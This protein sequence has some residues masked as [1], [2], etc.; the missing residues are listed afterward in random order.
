MVTTAPLFDPGDPAVAE[1]PYPMYRRLREAEPVHRSPLGFWVLSRYA[2]V[3]LVHQDQRFDRGLR[4]GEIVV[5]GWGGP[6]TVITR[7]ARRWILFM[8]PPDHT[9]IRGLV[10]SAF[11]YRTMAALRSRIQGLVDELIDAAVARGSL[12]VMADVAHP[13]PVTVISDL[14]GLPVDDHEQCRRW[15]EA[16]GHVFEPIQTDLKRQRAAQAIEEVSEYVRS[17]VVRR[18][19]SPG[20][21]LLTSLIA[22]EEAGDRLSDEELVSTVNLLLM[23]GHETTRNLIG[24]G[25]MALLRHPSEIERLRADPGLSPNAVEE[26]LRYDSPVQINRRMTRVDVEL[27]GQRIAAGDR[28]LTVIGAAH[29]DPSVFADPDVLDVSRPDVRP[30]SF[31]GGA[32]FCVGAGLSRIEA[33]VVFRTMI[34]RL[35]GLDF[36]A[37]QP[38][39]RDNFALRGLR[40]LPVSF[41]GVRPALAAT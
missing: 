16:I 25:T 4:Q 11:R 34:R 23:A 29:R 30:L 7:E 38:R 40:T 15:A 18:R 41:T 27:G 6:D 13:L 9:R 37:E 21:D 12:D 19:R 31:G 8:N 22:A 24:N 20:N 35:E 36:A 17:W 28:I 2:D 10:R 3:A 39:W 1:D 26:L 14:L 33:E 32:H 5:E